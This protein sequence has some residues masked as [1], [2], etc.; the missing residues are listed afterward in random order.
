[1]TQFF[2]QNVVAMI[3]DFDQTLIPGHMQA[4]LFAAYG[5]EERA[6]WAEVASLPERYKALGHEQ[7]SGE[8]LYLNHILDYTRSGR[9]QD[10]NN[11][12]LRALGAELA[13]Y[14]GLP[15]FLGE[16]KRVAAA[17]PY[18]EHEVKVE[19]Y[20]VSTGLSQMILGSAVSEHLDGVWGCEMI[21]EKGE[22][23][24]SRLSSIGYVLDNTTKTRA[25]FEINKGVNA[26]P[27]D[28]DVN[29]RMA[30]DARRV[31]ISQ[32][33]YV[34]DGPSDVP[35]FSVVKSLG[36]YTYA[37][38]NPKSERAYNQ[39]YDLLHKELRVD[40]M[41]AA[42]YTRGSD[43]WRWLMRTV[44]DVADGIVERRVRR[45]KRSVGNAPGHINE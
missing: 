5:V 8:L 10:L 27:N 38:Y 14:S 11:E 40:A 19:H 23:G 3:W 39:A 32:M 42:D 17:S 26:Q 6:F 4:P 12:K 35:V 30:E 31:P 15:D 33:I 37:V 18:K 20:V 24:K 43:T 2:S 7:T 41:G 45:L 1:M 13:F 22:D 44:K 29:A 16:I 21:D 34:A 28:I 36:G 9:F 25:I